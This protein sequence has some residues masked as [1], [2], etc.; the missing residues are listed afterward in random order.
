MRWLLLLLLLPSCCSSLRQVLL[1]RNSA[2]RKCTAAHARA[3]VSLK[4]E[5]DSLATAL[6]NV[7]NLRCSPGS[8]EAIG[9]PVN[10]DRRL[11]PTA[12]EDDKMQTAMWDM[13]GRDPKFYVSGLRSKEPSF[14]R[15]FT[16]DTWSAYTGRPPIL[17]WLVVTKTWRFSTVLRAVFPISAL[18]TLWAFSVA[19]LPA[20]LLPRT[21][22]VPMSL[23]GTALGL[24]LV[25]RTNNSYLRLTEAR[26]LWSQLLIHLREIGQSTA[27]ALLWSQSAATSAEAR[28]S[29]ARVCRYLAC[30]A[31]ELR[32]RLMGGEIAS[33]TAVLDALLKPEDAAFVAEQRLRPLALLSLLRH[34]IHQM[35]TEGHL[36]PHSA[37]KLEEEVL[38]GRRTRDLP[39]ASLPAVLLR[40]LMSRV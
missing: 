31:W 7:L 18:A 11:H 38:Y 22:P 27:T 28:D 5:Y 10:Q 4:G 17:R 37:R 34:E 9:C 40:L 25:F 32:A 13:I 16:H 6:E 39:A 26:K 20:A 33:D 2:P 1:S 19:S 3:V 12:D 8:L 23:M 29:A 35:V 30:I 36:P 15:L 24:L 21:S 14:T